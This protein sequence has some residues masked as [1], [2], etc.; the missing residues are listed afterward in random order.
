[1][2]FKGGITIQGTNNKVTLVNL[3]VT[4]QHPHFGRV[5]ESKFAGG[6][7]VKGTDHDIHVAACSAH[8]FDG[9]SAGAGL[10]GFG[11]RWHGGGPPGGHGPDGGRRRR[12][13]SVDDADASDDDDDGPADDSPPPVRG[14]SDSETPGPSFRRMSAATSGSDFVTPRRD[15][16]RDFD[17]VH[18]CCKSWC[19]AARRRTGGA[20]GDGQV[21]A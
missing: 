8:E 13:P 14:F 12:R 17:A 15:K 10:R 7:N 1:M 2:D 5:P 20:T 4:G 6:I 21:G 11:G 18:E 9:F 19:S 16:K 3:M